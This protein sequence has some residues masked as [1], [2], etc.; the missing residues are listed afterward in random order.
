MM[1]IAIP[2]E[3]GRLSSHFGHCERFA[4]IDIDE[5]TR[6]ITTK[7]EVTPPPHEPGQLPPWLANQGATL[8]IAGGMGGR[9]KQLLQDAGIGYVLG[10]P[11]LTA[12]ELVASYLNGTLQGGENACTHHEGEP[13]QDPTH[14]HGHGHTHGHAHGTKPRS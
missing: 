11:T 2:L 1:K 8:I 12:E 13:C 7:L 6:Q 14:G 5:K 3:G 9:A 10:A 4:F